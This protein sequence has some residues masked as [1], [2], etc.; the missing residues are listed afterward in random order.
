MSNILIVED[1]G[2]VGRQLT[3]MLKDLGHSVVSVAA[4]AEQCACLAS[5][6]PDMAL[7]QLTLADGATGL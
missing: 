7:G 3:Y 1:E 4:A 6:A 2:L 5:P